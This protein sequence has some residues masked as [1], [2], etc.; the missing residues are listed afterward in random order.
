MRNPIH[1]R[2]VSPVFLVIV[3]RDGIAFNA[4]PGAAIHTPR[5]RSSKGVVPSRPKA[6]SAAGSL[7]TSRG[8]ESSAIVASG[9][10]ADEKRFLRRHQPKCAPGILKGDDDESQIFLVVFSRTTLDASLLGYIS[11]AKARCRTVSH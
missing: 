6:K 2:I 8:N 4:A 7:G 3:E 10:G 1:A 5:I 11:R 9:T